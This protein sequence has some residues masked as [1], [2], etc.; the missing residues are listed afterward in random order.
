MRIR[1]TVLLMAAMLETGVSFWATVP[2]IT[3]DVWAKRSPVVSMKLVGSDPGFAWNDASSQNEGGGFQLSSLSVGR[4]VLRKL[5]ER[6]TATPSV[7]TSGPGGAEIGEVIIVGCLAEVGELSVT[8]EPYEG[9]PFPV[10]TNR[11]IAKSTRSSRR[12]PAPERVER[13]LPPGGM[14]AELLPTSDPHRFSIHARNLKAGQ[15]YI[16]RSSISSP[17]CPMSKGNNLPAKM[18][19]AGGQ[20]RADLTIL[21]GSTSLLACPNNQ[22]C[23]D[24]HEGVRMDSI[25]AL[26]KELFRWAS[27]AAEA[28]EG[29]WE[30]ADRPFPA[31]SESNLLKPPGLL[32]AGE[33]EGRGGQFKIDFAMVSI[34]SV[35]RNVTLPSALTKKPPKAIDTQPN[36]VEVTNA[37]ATENAPTTQ[38]PRANSAPQPGGVIAQKPESK[39]KSSLIGQI[40]PYKGPSKLAGAGANVRASVLEMVKG[41]QL[42]GFWPRTLQ[43]WYVRI[44]PVAQGK[45][46]GGPSNT[47]VIRFVTGPPD[48]NIIND[49]L[50]HKPAPY[51]VVITKTRAPK[52]P[53]PGE[54]GC[55]KVTR[56]TTVWT[57]FGPKSYGKN[58]ELCPLPSSND[59][60]PAS[61]FFSA[62]WEGLSSLVDYLAQAYSDLKAALLNLVA[63]AVGCG[64]GSSG[65]VCDAVN[66]GLQGALDV[67]MAAVGLPPSLPNVQELVNEGEDYLVDQVAEQTGVPAD[68]IRPVVD[69]AVKAIRNAQA[70][71]PPPSW[72]PAGVPVTPV[73]EGQYVPGTLV[74]ELT[75]SKH[76]KEARPTFGQL[77]C[78]VLTFVTAENHVGQDYF[79]ND[80]LIGGIILQAQPFPAPHPPGHDVS[81]PVVL[82]LNN[83]GP[84]HYRFQGYVTPNIKSDDPRSFFEKYFGDSGLSGAPLAPQGTWPGSATTPTTQSCDAPDTYDCCVDNQVCPAP[85][86]VQ[87]LEEWAALYRNAQDGL[88]WAMVSCGP[89]ND[90]SLATAP[91]PIGNPPY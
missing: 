63:G 17:N 13:S 79:W 35:P 9:G 24:S 72:V 1:R 19:L 28:T 67:G 27:S 76:W 25:S 84:G 54:A 20:E 6:R 30:V 88:A 82:Q 3:D 89:M 68:A 39:Q 58:D 91:F 2:I 50:T 33:V 38:A 21:G 37:L 40:N 60:S 70:N 29:T 15:L 55:V 11:D 14:R 26:G 86:D 18:W 64:S 47:V 44:V 4:P 61:E 73:P 51:D 8:L 16:A 80:T 65:T 36:Q 78:Q 87:W 69:S 56:N 71:P 62:L 83:Y 46:A 77:S 31:D 59:E 43:T 85:S 22:G 34:L 90:V 66:D 49:P 53:A 74:V 45:P 42:Q 81:I 41:V 32:W 10:T 52:F 5:T 7:M 57:F 12:Q 23:E 75:P 48:E